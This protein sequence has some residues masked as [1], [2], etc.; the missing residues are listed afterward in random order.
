MVYKIVQARYFRCRS[1]HSEAV[2]EI[3]PQHHAMT[4]SFPHIASATAVLLALFAVD[5]AIH[6]IDILGFQIP[7]LVLGISWSAMVCPILVL[8][9]WPFRRSHRLWSFDSSTALFGLSLIA[10]LAIELL[11]HDGSRGYVLSLVFGSAAAWVAFLLTRAHLKVFG[12]PDILVGTFAAVAVLLALGQLLLLSLQLTGVTFPLVRYDELVDRNSLTLLVAAGFYFASLPLA[13]GRSP[14]PQAALLGLLAFGFLY[15]AMNRARAAEILL[16]VGVSLGLI[17]TFLPGRLRATAMALMIVATVS[18]AAFSGIFVRSLDMGTGTIDTR[19]STVYRAQANSQMFDLFIQNPLFGSGLANVMHAAAGGYVSHT[20]Y[21]MIPAAFGLAGLVCLTVL[22]T[23]WLR[24]GSRRVDRLSFLVFVL[25]TLTF[26]NDPAVWLGLG[27]AIVSFGLVRS[28]LPQRTAVVPAAQTAHVMTRVAA[29]WPLVAVAAALLIGGCCF[30][31]LTTL[32]YGARADVLIGRV[33]LSVPSSIESTREATRFVELTVLR[34]EAE[35]RNACSVRPLHDRPVV[36]VA[37]KAGTSDEA[38]RRAK[39]IVD[40]IIERHEMAF[41][42]RLTTLHLVNGRDED[43]LSDLNRAAA[44]MRREVMESGPGTGLTAAIA[45]VETEAWILREQIAG[46][47]RVRGQ[48]VMTSIMPPGVIGYSRASWSM[49][50]GL[51]LG[52][53]VL[54]LLGAFALALGEAFAGSLE[55]HTRRTQTDRPLVHSAL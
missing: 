40:L 26:F 8:F 53:V 4:F 2:E 12:R 11:V 18:I 3:I 32:P 15:A 5:I 41:E 55:P 17:R 46:R 20:L 13:A 35:M 33:G 28:E 39:R 19:S 48:Y 10:W 43:R 34:Q 21:L 54:V 25:T 14:I 42:D 29:R 27:F 44:G 49:L 36:V 9:F 37:C 16:L 22:V 51:A 52:G 7:R 6:A 50:L 38:S 47:N 31:V 1:S 24:D 30:A 45:V 23:M